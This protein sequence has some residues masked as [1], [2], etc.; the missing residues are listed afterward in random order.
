MSWGRVQGGVPVQEKV[1][2]G[3]WMGLKPR[4]LKGFHL[5]PEEHGP[6]LAIS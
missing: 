2:E 1:V 6:K 5:L 3:G 4:P